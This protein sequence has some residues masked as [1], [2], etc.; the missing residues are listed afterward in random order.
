MVSIAKMPTKILRKLEI[1]LDQK[2][3]AAH[4]SATTP[5]SRPATFP[6]IAGCTNASRPNKA[7]QMLSGFMA[8]FPSS[9]E[10]GSNSAWQNRG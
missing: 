4:R 5:S 7:T 3:A 8:V 6:W 1:A 9:N 2:V 10:S